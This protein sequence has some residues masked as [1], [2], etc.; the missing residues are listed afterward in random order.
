MSR[1]CQ[2]ARRRGAAIVANAWTTTGGS[3][4]LLHQVGRK[5]RHRRPIT[6]NNGDELAA[7]PPSWPQGTPPTPDCGQQR[8]RA[9]SSS[10]KLAARSATDARLRTTT[11]RSGGIEG[12]PVPADVAPNSGDRSC[13]CWRPW[14][15]PPATGPEGSGR[16]AASRC[17]PNPEAARRT[18]SR[19]RI[20]LA[21]SYPRTQPIA[22]A[23]QV[24]AASRRRCPG[25]PRACP[26]RAAAG[27]RRPRSSPPSP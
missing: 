23:A 26:L 13:R 11:S 1:A 6:D 19:P 25:R 5:E 12:R 4:Q 24:T 21:L 8:G 27:S 10:T 16:P 20:P 14:R 2:V 17:G 3:W 18:R 15:R 22:D 7:P 9:D